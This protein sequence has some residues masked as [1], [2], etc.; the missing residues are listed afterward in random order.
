[1]SDEQKRLKAAVQLLR[2]LRDRFGPSPLLPVDFAAQWQQLYPTAQSVWDSV[3][4][5]LKEKQL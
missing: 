2:I 3:D 4:R 5:V 1:M